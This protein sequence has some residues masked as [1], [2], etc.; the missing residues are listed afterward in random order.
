MTA[1][2]RLEIRA[3]EIR[4]RL[5]ELA[6]VETLEDEQRSEISTLRGEMRDTETQ[7]QAAIEAEPEVRETET[8]TEDREL[9]VII[10]GASVGEI[11]AAAVEHRSTDG[12]TRELQAHR[13]L[14][15][16]VIPLDLLPGL[17]GLAEIEER[18]VTPAPSTVGANQQEIIHPV[19]PMT[20]A[21]FLGIP[22]P[23]VAVGESVY[24][25]LSTGATAAT[26]AAGGNVGETTGAFTASSLEPSRLQASFFYR[27]R[28]CGQ[29]YGLGRSATA[30]PER[31][32]HGRF[33]QGHPS[34]C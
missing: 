11:M 28:G 20:V 5:A 17:A 24:P 30:Q 34:G 13:K 23:T 3:S 6:E 4:G 25:V 32:A 10:S 1:K 16:N 27:R 8:T 29:V 21:D 19:F 14:R 2:Q 12:Q 22:R 18:A 15:S 26:P 31:I 33:G 7:L 9:E